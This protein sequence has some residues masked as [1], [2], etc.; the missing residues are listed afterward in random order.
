MRA[1]PLRVKAKHLTA[2]LGLAIVMFGTGADAQQAPGWTCGPGGMGASRCAG[3]WQMGPQMMGGSMARHHQAM[4]GGVPAP[5]N[6]M[7]NPLPKAPGTLDRGVVVYQENC[8]SCHG[9]AGMG[10][11]EAGKELSPPPAN[12]AWLSRMPMM[13][14][15]SFLYWAIAEGGVPFGTGMPAFKDA[16]SQDDIWAVIT[17]LQAGLP[18]R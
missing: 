10:D 2:T 13:R 9:S 6:A 12:L 17:Y 15:D 1:D 11:G 3:Q 4:M 16:L 18:S 14:S 8:Q 5:Y 7:T